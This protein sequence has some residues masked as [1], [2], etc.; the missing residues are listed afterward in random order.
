MSEPKVQEDELLPFEKKP[1]AKSAD[2]SKQIALRDGLG[3][4]STV[5][6]QFRLATLYCKSGMLPSRFKTPEQV[7]TAMHFAAEHFP[8][9]VL[10]ALR[11]IAI[12][13]GTPAMF[14]DLPLA[15][16][17]TSHKWAGKSEYFLD[18]EG[19]KI[20]EENKNLG[21]EIWA[22]VCKTRRYI[23]LAN[24][25]E[26][27]TVFSV[28]DAKRAGLWGRNVWAKYPQDMMKYKARSR[29]LKDHFPDAL[30][31]VA[32]GEHDFDTVIDVLPDKSIAD[33]LN[34]EY[35]D[36]QEG[37]TVPQGSKE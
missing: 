23:N 9:T 36:A 19:N 24:I 30:N 28:D 8:K 3:M 26:H 29:N 5:E 18:K 11:Q 33:E 25:E 7:L 21:A 12:I 32:I 15:K 17:M 1:E 37:S 27:T 31:G 10:T 16:A 35:F 13:E 34:A 14:G 4:P 2:K 22:A 20:C 6:E